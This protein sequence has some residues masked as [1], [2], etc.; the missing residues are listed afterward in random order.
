MRVLPISPNKYYYTNY[1]HNKELKYKYSTSA[2]PQS[3]SGIR[4]SFFNLSIIAQ[5][6]LVIVAGYL[7]KTEKIVQINNKLRPPKEHNTV[8]SPNTIQETKSP[9]ED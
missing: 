6:A 2:Q 7:G 4:P 5:V 1:A 8:C 9:L 3:F